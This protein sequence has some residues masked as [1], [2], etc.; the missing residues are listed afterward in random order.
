MAQEQQQPAGECK[1]ARELLSKITEEIAKFEAKKLAD[2]KKELEEF[3]KKQ[4]GLVSEYKNKFPD[5][6]KAWCERQGD[7]DRLCNT[8]TCEFPPDKIKKI[9]SDCICKPIHTLCCLGY[10]IQQRKKCFLPPIEVNRETAQAAFDKAKRDLQALMDLTKNI[11]G[12]LKRD[13]ELV[14]LINKTQGADRPGVIYQF[15]FKNG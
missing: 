11:E 1:G 3:V 7:V 9:I 6:R 2:L 8:I 15:G 10:S 12:D 14:D 4:D 13:K 5:L